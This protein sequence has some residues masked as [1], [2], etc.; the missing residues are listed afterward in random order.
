M[1][2]NPRK[3]GHAY[4]LDIRDWFRELGWNR[5]VSSRSE[6]KNKDDQGIDLCYT[7][8]FNVQ[9]KAVEKLGSLHDVLARMP[10]DTN[11]NVVFHKKNRKGTIV[12]MTIE[13]FK[14]IVEM[15]ISHQILKP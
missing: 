13:D 15:L 11:Y 1:A 3:K 7:D 4:E 6:S 8:P 14:E 10:K 9:A 5:A 12:A 2:I